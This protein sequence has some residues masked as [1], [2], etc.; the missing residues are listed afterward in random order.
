M[1]FRLFDMYHS[2]RTNFNMF[3]NGTSGKGKTTF[4]MK[5]LTSILATN[6]KVVVID[7]QGEYREL[8]Q[9]LMDKLL[10]WER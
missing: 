2:N 8:A 3:I 6:N 9:N 7:P 10:I 5:L 1:S 4:T